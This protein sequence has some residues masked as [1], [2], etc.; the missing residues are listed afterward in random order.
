M[1]FHIARCATVLLLFTLA[2]CANIQS[3]QAP[4]VQLTRVELLDTRPGSLEQRFGIGLRLINPNNRSLAVDGLDFELDLNG[5]RLARGVTNEA[6]ELPRLGDAETTV[7]VTTS[8]LDVLRQALSISSRADEEI[9]YRL[10][11]RLHLGSGFVRSVPFD[12][13]GTLTP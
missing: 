13:R 9:E 8:V 12:H 1:P 11:G 7:V 10:R 3:L 6:F 2:G 4:E 5:R